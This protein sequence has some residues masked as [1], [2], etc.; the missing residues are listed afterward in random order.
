MK[1][2]ASFRCSAREM[3][4]SLSSCLVRWRRYYW[5]RTTT[6]C[7]S[8]WQS[9]LISDTKLPSD[10]IM[11]WVRRTEGWGL[12][13]GG[14][15]VVVLAVRGVGGEGG[16][17]GIWANVQACWRQGGVLI[18]GCMHFVKCRAINL[19]NYPPP[20]RPPPPP[21]RPPHPAPQ[22]PSPNVAVCVC[23][24]PSSSITQTNFPGGPCGALSHRNKGTGSSDP[25]LPSAP[26][27]LA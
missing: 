14:A 12:G 3:K 23:L 7:P 13:G 27:V 15:E 2:R 6:D 9:V 25:A 24:S 16:W 4:G 5:P 10:L 26:D 19:G 18:T 22:F 21:P 11:W 20:A 1:R 8:L 17:C